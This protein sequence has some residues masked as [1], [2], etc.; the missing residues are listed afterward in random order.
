MLNLVGKLIP[1]S[2]LEKEQQAHRISFAFST[3]STEIVKVG[4]KE[5]HCIFQPQECPGEKVTL[6]IK[7]N[8]K[9]KMPNFCIKLILVTQE[10]YKVHLTTT[11]TNHDNIDEEKVGK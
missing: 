4:G 1:L 10:L 8:S 6:R 11:T 7:H 3:Q 2:L 9:K 5:R